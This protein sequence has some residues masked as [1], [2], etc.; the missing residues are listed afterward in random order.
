MLEN[1]GDISKIQEGVPVKS[2]SKS[3]VPLQISSLAATT[4]RVGLSQAILLVFDEFAVMIV[5]HKFDFGLA[6][7]TW[8]VNGLTER[9]RGDCREAI[10]TDAFL[11]DPLF[12]MLVQ[13]HVRTS[14]AIT[15]LRENF[16]CGYNR[17]VLIDNV[18]NPQLLNLLRQVAWEDGDFSANLK[19]GSATKAEKQSGTIAPRGTVSQ[20]AFVAAPEADRFIHQRKLTGAKPGRENSPAM[21]AERLV[22]RAMGGAGFLGWLGAIADMELGRAGGINLKLHGPGNFLRKHSDARTGRKLC[23][24]LYLHEHWEEHFGGRFLLHL[25]DGSAKVIEPL[26]NRMVLFDVTHDN[27]HQIE[28]LG[29]V[30]E[31][32]V[33]I[34]YSAW[35]G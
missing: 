6:L 15:Q 10:M 9:R 29:N 13:A 16:A 31:G 28:P 8:A 14:E 32:W 18:I 34:N 27:F 7:V 11:S 30:P 26:P 1:L 23:L 17:H 20:A 2:S 5:P 35:F 3:E 24:V 19:L 25:A 4:V 22:R 21:Q 33:R 12:A